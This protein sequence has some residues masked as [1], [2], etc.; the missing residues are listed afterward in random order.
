[1]NAS[2][3]GSFDRRLEE[4]LRACDLR[5][6]VTSL[7]DLAALA[8]PTAL[9]PDLIVL[10]LR[11]KPALPSAVPL[12][13]QRHPRVGVLVVAPQ[14]DPTLMLASMR[15]GVNEFLTDPIAVDD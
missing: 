13:R 10:D 1:M 12:I 4:L 11:E 2:L 5:T 3:Y 6:T 7:D 15:A 9:P 8:S 14:L